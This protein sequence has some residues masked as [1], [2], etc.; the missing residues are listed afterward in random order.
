[1]GDTFVTS[2]LGN[3]L[4]SSRSSAP[5]YGFGT[6]TRENREKVFIS[7]EHAE[8]SNMPLSPG[9]A[10]YGALSTLGPQLTDGRSE[11]QWVFAKNERFSKVSADAGKKPH[12]YDLRGSIGGQLESKYHS[13]PT[14]SMGTSTRTG[15]EKVFVSDDHA[16][17]TFGGKGS[18]GPA[19]YDGVAS[20]GKQANSEKG[21]PPTWLFGTL[22]RFKNPELKTAAKT[23]APDAYSGN[24][25]AS[26]GPQTLGRYESSPM[27][28]FGSSTRDHMAKVF[29]SVSHEKTKSYGKGSPG[30]NVYA[31]Q[32]SVGPQTSSKYRSSPARGF[33]SCDRWSTSKMAARL[34]NTPAP[35]AYN[36]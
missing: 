5:L 4:V 36:I 32:G 10:K 28:G 11:P 35:G 26:C 14:F 30:P 2:T 6:S 20:I 33:G 12:S 13:Q 24:F 3:Q 7:T 23:P 29:M 1:M 25:P 34:G 21:T 8:L 9:P 18:P 19:S 17:A 31:L 15:V 22:E 16:L 27:P